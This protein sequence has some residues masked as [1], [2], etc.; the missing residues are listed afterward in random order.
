[1][2]KAEQS[3]AI[4]NLVWGPMKSFPAWP[5]KI[6]SIENDEQVRVKWFGNEKYV[7]KIDKKSLQTLSEG[8]D[9]HHLARKKCRT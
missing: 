7:S 9:A 3:F 5:G 4:G 1:M 6:I 8:L 2:V